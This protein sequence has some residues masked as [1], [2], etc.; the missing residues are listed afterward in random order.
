MRPGKTGG[1]EYLQ[2][3]SPLRPF[4]SRTDSFN[5]LIV[6]VSTNSSTQHP[7]WRRALTQFLLAGMVLAATVLAGTPQVYAQP[8]DPDDFATQ[9]AEVAEATF[10][11]S[12]TTDAVTAAAEDAEHSPE[13][14]WRL[15]ATLDETLSTE[16]MQ[17]FARA[18][19]E[20][21]PAPGMRGGRG[22]R[23][24]RGP[25]MR[26]GRGGPRGRGMHRPRAMGP[27]GGPLMNELD[28][29]DEQREQVRQL[30][31]DHRAEMQKLR[32]EMR[33]EVQKIL[34]EEQRQ[35]L[36]SLRTERRGQRM[37]GRAQR[38]A[39]RNDAL[40]LRDDQI[41]AFAEAWAEH[42]SP[43]GMRGAPG[44]RHAEMRAAVAEILS[45]EQL[46]M[47]DLHHALMMTVRPHMEGKNRDARR[48]NGP[49]R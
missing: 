4:P 32:A 44:A 36:D 27:E 25:G 41:D 18:L 43:R 42:Q 13:G 21:A 17:T 39:A 48:G 45:E 37:A 15:V 29:S 24:G 3:V 23:A 35:T 8:D 14:M 30:R 33:A 49:R 31:A 47:M 5:P 38:Q 7:S 28:L 12:E 1:E 10:G 26:A 9:I 19:Q 6:M 22:M 11:T 46:A 40:G 2:R 34:T 16:Q 20:Q